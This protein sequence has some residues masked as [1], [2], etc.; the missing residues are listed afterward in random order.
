MCI[1]SYASAIYFRRLDLLL[2]I[3]IYKIIYI[4]RVRTGTQTCSIHNETYN[5][6]YGNSV[7]NRF[8]SLFAV[9]N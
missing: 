1:N 9:N 8:R 7:K 3:L 6:L 5:A 2:N 4:Y